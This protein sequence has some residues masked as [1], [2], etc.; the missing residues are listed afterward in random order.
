MNFSAINLELNEFDVQGS[1]ILHFKS[2]GEL[3]VN[4]FFLLATEKELENNWKIFSNIIAAKFQNSEYMSEEN[5]EFEKWNFYII[6]VAKEKLSK[7]LKNKI[8]NDRFSS[9]KIV[10]DNFS[11]DF[12]T[13]TANN[14]I[15]KHITNTDLRDILAQTQDKI[16]QEYQPINIQLWKLVH[17]DVSFGRDTDL[18][19][20]IID[21]IIQ[22]KNEN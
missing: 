17:N 10:E 9:R 3:A 14:L 21:Q 11:D 19:R 15:I 18:Q 22:L 2:D 5:K 12:N 13:V 7:E 16:Q 6:Y 4:V 8:E 20:Q 1:Q